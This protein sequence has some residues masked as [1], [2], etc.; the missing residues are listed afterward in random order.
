[1]SNIIGGIDKK[2]IV[3]SYDMKGSLHKREVLQKGEKVDE[4]EHIRKTLKDVD[5]ERL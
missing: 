1:M 4:K 2:Y 5:F 3:R